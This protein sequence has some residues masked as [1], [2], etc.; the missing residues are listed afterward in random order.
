[1]GMFALWDSVCSL[2]VLGRERSQIMDS[3]VGYRYTHVTIA[4][5]SNLYSNML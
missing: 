2:T 5:I 3:P 1:M 4:N